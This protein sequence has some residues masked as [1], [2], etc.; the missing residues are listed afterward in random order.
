MLKQEKLTQ[1]KYTKYFEKSVTTQTHYG[2]STK[3]KSGLKFLFIFTK[4]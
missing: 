1:E 3:T 2:P 4:S